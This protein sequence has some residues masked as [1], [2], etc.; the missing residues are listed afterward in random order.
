VSYL[1]P[2]IPKT[3]FQFVEFSNEFDQDG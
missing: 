2:V 3:F 1:L